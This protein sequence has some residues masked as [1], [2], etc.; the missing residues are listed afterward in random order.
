MDALIQK[1]TDRY[2][3]HTHPDVATTVEQ[4]LI[5]LSSGIYTED[6]RFIFELLQNAVD[7]FNN[8]CETL[9]IKIVI[10]DQYVVFMHNG[11]AFS[12]RDIEGLC[13]IGNGNKTDDIKKIGYKGI[14]FKSVFM[15]STSVTVKSNDSCFKFDKSHWDGYWEKH[16]TPAFGTKDTT[17]N[18]LMPWQII[19]IKTDVPIKI[20]TAGYNVITYVRVADTSTIER[21][22][23]D[24]MSSSQFL[25]FL[26]TKNIKMSFVVNGVVRNTIT[27]TTTKGQ[28]LLSS[29][30]EEDS[31]WLIYTNNEVKV[32]IELRDAIYADTN[33]PQKLKDAQTFDLSFAIAIDNNGKLKRLPQKDAVIYTY[34]PTSFKFG[35]DGFPFLVNANFITDAGRLQLHKDSEWNKL[36]FSKI[37]SEFLTWV[38]DLS[39]TYKNYYEILPQKSYGQTNTLEEVFAVEMEKAID[40]IAFIPRQN[41]AR[42]KMLASETV[43]D[44]IGFSEAVSPEKLIEHINRTYKCEFSVDNFTFPVKSTRIFADY[45]VFVL[46]KDKVKTLLEDVQLFDEMTV[47]YNVKLIKFLYDF[48]TQNPNDADDLMFVLSGTKFLLDGNMEIRTPNTLFFYTNYKKENALANNVPLLNEA[49]NIAMNK[50]NISGWLSKLGVRQLSNISFIKYLYKNEGYITTENA[51]EIGKFVFHIYQTEDLFG[52]I[53]SYELSYVKF[54]STKGN[55]KSAQELYLSKKYK[56][57]LNIEPSLDEDIFISEQYCE[58]SSPAE[59]KVFL[60]KMGVKEDISNDTEVVKLYANDYDDRY[61]K[62]F[63]DNIKKCSERYRWI[64][65]G[66]WNLDSGDY[67]FRANR[68]NYNTF[69]FLTRCNKYNF[70]KLIFSRLLSKYKP[71]EI[72]TSI[73]SVYGDTGIFARSIDSELL[74]LLNCNINHFKWVIENCAVLPTVKQDCRKAEEIYSNSIPQIKEIAGNYLPVIDIEDAISESWQTYLGLKNC[75]TLEDYLFL[76]TAFTTDVENVS[77]NKNRITLIYQKLVELDC[78][79]SEKQ[80]TQIKEWAAHNK[81]LS[82]NDAFMSPSELSHITIDGFNSRNRVYIGN[83]LDKEKILELLSVMGVTIITEDKISTDYKGKKEAK[84]L[85]EILYGKLS[86]LALIAMGEQADEATYTFKKHEMM[87][88]L[89]NTYFYH[90]EAINLTYGGDHD[91]FVAKTTFSSKNEF[92]YTGNLRPANIEPL[93]TPLCKYLGIKG[94]ERELFIFFIENREGIRQNL[95]EKGYN[96]ELLEEETIAESGTIQTQLSYVP[97]ETEQERNLI[98]G[99]KGEIIVYEKLKDMGYAPQCPSISSKDDYDRKIEMNGKTYYCKISYEKYDMS[100]TTKQGI[101]VYMEVKATT[102]QKEW[103]ANMPISY[104]ELSMIERCNANANERYL[105]VRVFGVGQTVQDIYLFDAYL[106]G[107]KTLKNALLHE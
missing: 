86:P 66:G 92:Y 100:F 75:L 76:L 31:R 4:S 8:Q 28:V 25:L 93:L 23:G 63:F 34:L 62:P 84:E 55:L 2:V 3:L 39:T 59:W 37:P 9:D 35:T 51:I 88:L 47:D 77:D 30:G 52:K 13:D 80:R 14:G 43:I 74:T 5:Q 46:D 45:G 85:K 70:S 36:I 68:I 24:L 33:T 94:K 89:D 103:Q 54:L 98:T 61:D 102:G 50:L 91:D 58:E 44:K 104:N 41:D 48:C 71:E 22:I 17:K 1:L 10:N 26:Q 49:V 105:L 42:E 69:S 15:R 12:P 29:N 78:L 64:S 19:P 38:K 106:L 72:Q 107:D 20:D 101:K 90:C 32:P 87:T 95:E 97:S 67:S 7:A 81:I 99:F 16:W 65:F 40:S 53:P 82:K 96:V 83:C 79:D 21:K 18:Y 57:E 11:D 60:L 56:P 27:K 73:V 6:E